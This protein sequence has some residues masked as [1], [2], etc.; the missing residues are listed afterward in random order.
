MTNG[1]DECTGRVEVRH[2]EEWHTVCDTDWNLSK[3]QVV[4]EQLECGH[5]M[6]APGGAHFGQ[7]SGSVVAAS[8]LC[9][10]NVTS[11]QRCSR[12]GFQSSRCGHDHDAGTLCA[13]KTF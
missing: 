6:N 11:L 4:C 10:N 9:F 8:D 1:K 13:G 3:A 7:G 2:G 12:N 5:A